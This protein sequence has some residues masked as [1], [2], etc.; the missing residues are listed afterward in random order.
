MIL[1]SIL[2]KKLDLCGR[3]LPPTEALLQS[4]AKFA[5]HWCRRGCIEGQNLPGPLVVPPARPCHSDQK[6]NPKLR[7]SL[8]QTLSQRGYN[9]QFIYIYIYVKLEPQGL[10]KSLTLEQVLSLCIYI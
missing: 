5:G 3:I 6:S 10:Q 8:S 4:G 2:G 9:N 1:H 7:Q